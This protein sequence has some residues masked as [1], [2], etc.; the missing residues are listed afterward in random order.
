MPST[1]LILYG[2]QTGTTESFAKIVHSFAMA[3]GLSPRLV[4][5]DDFDHAKLVDEDV[6]V[7]LTSTFYNG[8]FPTN[9]TR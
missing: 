4:S 5:D 2:S 7:F 3:R 9:F 1:M 8:E 6:V